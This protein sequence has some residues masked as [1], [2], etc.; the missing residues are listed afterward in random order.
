VRDVMRVI[1][2]AGFSGVGLVADRK[3]SG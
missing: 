1:N 3:V 2:E